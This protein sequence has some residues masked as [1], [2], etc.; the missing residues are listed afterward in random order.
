MTVDHINRNKLDNRRCNLRVA[1]NSQNCRNR[2]KG[3]NNTSGYKG[4]SYKKKNKKFAA[5]ITVD[6][7]MHNLGLFKTA[8]EASLVYNAAAVRFHK[9]FACLN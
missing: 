8:E 5:R 6:G 1:S 9:D 4:V 7:R 2:E 3:K